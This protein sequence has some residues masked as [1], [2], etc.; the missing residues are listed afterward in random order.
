MPKWNVYLL[1]SNCMPQN[2]D[3]TRNHELGTFGNGN[4]VRRVALEPKNGTNGNIRTILD[5]DRLCK[6]GE[7]LVTGMYLFIEAQSPRTALLTP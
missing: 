1:L 2:C 5:Y 6:S 3:N 7:L 4:K